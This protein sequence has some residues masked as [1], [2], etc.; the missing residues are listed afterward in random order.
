MQLFLTYEVLGNGY[1]DYAAGGWVEEDHTPEYMGNG[2]PRGRGRG[3][4]GRGRRGGY[5][6][7]PDYQQDGGYYDEAPVPAPA[8][9]GQLPS[10]LIVCICAISQL[11]NLLQLVTR[12]WSRSW[13]WERPVQRQRTWW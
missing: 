6:G 8:R 5:T 9:G 3:F 10:R 1:N 12:S 7:Q 13:P 4:R 11:V 2:Y